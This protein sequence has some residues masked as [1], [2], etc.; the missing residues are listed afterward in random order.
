MVEP[1]LVEVIRDWLSSQVRQV[2]GP[3]PSPCLIFNGNPDEYGRISFDGER[4][5]AHRLAWELHYGRLPPK[6][7]SLEVL[8]AIYQNPKQSIPLRKA[9]ARDALPFGGSS[10][11]E[12]EIRKFFV[13]QKGCICCQKK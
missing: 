1:H 7:T 3:L 6:P 13:G 10:C 8:R 4:Y 2:R 9:A 12:S 5:Y 11:S